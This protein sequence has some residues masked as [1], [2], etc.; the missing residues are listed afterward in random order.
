MNRCGERRE[1]ELKR[2][3]Q[4][5]GGVE[6][7]LKRSNGRDDG[8][9]SGRRKLKD[10]HPSFEEGSHPEHK[11]TRTQEDPDPSPAE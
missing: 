5:W 4:A 1:E 7:D 3:K 11:V 2:R 8:P 10:V 9:I 6:T